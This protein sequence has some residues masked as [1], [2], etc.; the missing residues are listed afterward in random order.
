MKKGIVYSMKKK[1]VLFL[2]TLLFVFIPSAHASTV[3][4]RY[5]KEDTTNNVKIVYEINFNISGDQYRIHSLVSSD[6]DLSTGKQISTVTALNG[7]NGVNLRTNFSVLSQS[8]CPS[9]IS[10]N[11]D[12]ISS[13]GDMLLVANGNSNSG[14]SNNG[15]SGGVSWLTSSKVSCGTINNIPAKIPDITATI[16]NI[17]QFAVP[18]ILVIMGGFDLVKGVMSGK[19]DEIK[20]GQQS[21]IKRLLVGVIIFFIIAL[22]KLLVGIAATNVSE[23]NNI[24]NCIDCFTKG[25]SSCK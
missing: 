24:I 17:L 19:E 25:S 6:T 8:D 7:Q 5:E 10:L 1:I 20:K 3:T 12:Y 23:S 2:V 16:V 9:S 14:N 4:C 13:G 18:V 11:N 15:N 22:V 21:L